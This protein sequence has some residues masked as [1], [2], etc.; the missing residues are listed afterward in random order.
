LSIFK[1]CQ[2]FSKNIKQ[3]P[4]NSQ[5]NQGQISLVCFGSFNQGG[6][7][8]LSIIKVFIVQAV[9]L[10]TIYNTSIVFS[11]NAP[12]PPSTFITNVTWDWNTKVRLADGSD[13]WPITWAADDNQYT[14]WGDG[15]GF[16][17]TADGWPNRVSMGF[18]RIAGDFNSYTGTNI[19]GGTDNTNGGIAAENLAQFGGKSYGLISVNGVL[20]AWWGRDASNSGS[21]SFVERTGPIKSTD[22]GATWTVASWYWTNND[23]LYGPSFI[24]Y[25]KDNAGAI[26]DYVYSYFPRQSQWGLHKPGQTDLAR[27]HKDSIMDQ[28]AYVWFDSL[29]GNGNPTWTTLNNRNPVFEDPNGVATTSGNYNQGLKKFLLTNLHSEFSTAYG[30]DQWGLFESD[31]PWGPWKTVAYYQP[32]WNDE[33][34]CISYYF[35][36]KWWSQDG[37]DFTLV[38][39]ADD[40][41]GTVRGHFEIQYQPVDKIEEAAAVPEEKELIQAVPNPF[42]PYTKISF[43]ENWLGR[44]MQ[45]ANV[46]GERVYYKPILSKRELMWNAENYSSG[47]YVV[48]VKDHKSTQ[49]KK[50]YLV[51]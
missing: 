21:A 32:T 15:G 29:D 22:F 16:G 2:F 23:N 36:P 14:N 7:M 40:A 50:I 13:N 39:T 48:S 30:S 25:G 4:I 6:K 11:Q 43:P 34:G 20:Y 49:F 35:A 10:F 42:N 27:V 46:K 47:L 31:K 38:Y 44:Q 12:Y 3:F 45:I 26:D 9:V 51:R 17:H 1:T 24:N 28:A 5:F 19:W 8:N 18:A 41:W 33:R 37:K